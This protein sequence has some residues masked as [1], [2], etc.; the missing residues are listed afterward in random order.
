MY[1]II[2]QKIKDLN[3]EEFSSV[4]NGK[5]MFYNITFINCCELNGIFEAENGSISS[6]TTDMT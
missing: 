2:D 6:I 3:L 4:F 1:Y 5:G